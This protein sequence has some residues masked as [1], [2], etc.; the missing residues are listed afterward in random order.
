RAGIDRT[1]LALFELN[2]DLLEPKPIKARAYAP[3]PKYPH[4]DYDLALLFDHGVAWSSIEALVK[5]CDPLILD[6]CFADEYRGK[7]IP[8]GKKSVA[9]QMTLGDPEATL[10]SEQAQAVADKVLAKIGK[11]LGGHLRDK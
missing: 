7:Q 1:S 5:K 3:L 10:T 2:L 6:V 11:E 4:V 9:F 8:E